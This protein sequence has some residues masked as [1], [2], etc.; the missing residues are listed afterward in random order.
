L[1]GTAIGSVG[2]EPVRV[3]DVDT[4]VAMTGSE[5]A[6]TV[7][8]PSGVLSAEEGGTTGTVIDSGTAES[9]FSR[10]S[11]LDTFFSASFPIWLSKGMSRPA[12]H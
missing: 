1:V 2:D 3:A 10:P 12:P 4:A 8:V 5:E 9:F 6:G 11:G 7:A